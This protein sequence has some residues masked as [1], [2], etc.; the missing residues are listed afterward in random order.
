MTRIAAVQ[1]QHAG[2]LVRLAYR[3][4]ERQMGRMV[5]NIALYAHRPRLLVGYGLFEKAVASAPRVDQRLRSLAV[6]KSA[7]MQGCEFCIDLGSTEARASGISDEQ[8]LD[9]HRYRD[10][11][12][13]DDTERLVLDL[14]VA[15][16]STPT[17]V[18]DE[19]VAA[20]RGRFDEAQLVE[21]VNLIALENL[22]SRFNGAFGIGSAGFSEGRVCARPEGRATSA[23][24]GR[25]TVGLDAAAA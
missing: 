14:A 13:F 16:T 15:M 7:A 8:L 17:Q 5:D 19:L 18:T 25:E 12:R 3:L 6:L 2:P 10:S 21:L 4:T 22:R 1:R 9:L 24:P 20:L 11:D 23:T